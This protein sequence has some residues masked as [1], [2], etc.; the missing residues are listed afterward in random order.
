M[1]TKKLWFID[2]WQM[3]TWSIRQRLRFDD[4]IKFLIIAIE[5]I[6]EIISSLINVHNVSYNRNDQEKS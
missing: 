3:E 6:I 1:I 5:S 4:K 2:R